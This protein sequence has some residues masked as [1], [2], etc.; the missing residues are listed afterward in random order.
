MKQLHLCDI[1]HRDIKPQN[2]LLKQGA[3]GE[4]VAKLA[5]FGLAKYINKRPEK[6]AKDDAP[7]Q[8]H[9]PFEALL[10]NTV[11]GTLMYMAPEILERR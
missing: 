9:D 3:N 2:V 11:C 5:D 6:S 10:E 4:L 7:D 1:M 8:E